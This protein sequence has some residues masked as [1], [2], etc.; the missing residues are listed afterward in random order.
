[1]SEN[2]LKTGMQALWTQ[3]TQPVQPSKQPPHKTGG[4]QPTGI[5]AVWG[6]NQY[7]NINFTDATYNRICALDA[8]P[9]DRSGTYTFQ[10]W[11]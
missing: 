9:P 7:G 5:E 6:G 10:A 11:G 2:V 1:M 3:W 8:T 4:T